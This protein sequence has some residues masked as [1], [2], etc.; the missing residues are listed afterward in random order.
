MDENKGDKTIKVIG[1][2]GGIFIAIISISFTFGIL[3][4]DVSTIKEDVKNLQK[5]TMTSEAIRLLVKDEEEDLIPKL[6]LRYY[7]RP[8]FDNTNSDINTI[9]LKLERLKEDIKDL[10]QQLKK[11]KDGRVH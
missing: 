1:A 5:H 2:F 9:N 8:Q 7:T 6:D 10:E 3:S 11:L 4:N